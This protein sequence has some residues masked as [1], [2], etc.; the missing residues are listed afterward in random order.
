MTRRIR[1]W[2]AAMLTAAGLM[3][4]L[5]VAAHAGVS[6][7]H[8]NVALTPTAVEYAVMLAVLCRWFKST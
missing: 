7:A 8:S 5:A 3:V 2:I 4:G 6:Q 1:L